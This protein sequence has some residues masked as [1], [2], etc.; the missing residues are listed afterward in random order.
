MDWRR[1]PCRLGELSAAHEVAIYFASTATAFV[2]SP[3]DEG[4]TTTAVTAG[5]YALNAAVELAVVGF[6]VGAGILLDF[7][8]VKNGGFRAEEAHC[9]EDELGGEDALCA[10]DGLG[11]HAALWIF[12]PLDIDDFDACEVTSLIADKAL[13]RNKILAGIGAVESCGFFLTVVHLVNAG[14]F[15]PRIISSTGFRR[16]AHDFE[17]GDRLAS[18]ADRSA[19]AVGTGI[20]ATD[21]DDVLTLSRNVLRLAVEVVVEERLGVV[22]EELHREVNT[23]E[24]TTFDWE[25]AGVCS[26]HGKDN[27][28][29]V[30]TE[31]LCGNIHTDVD[32][33]LK[34]YAFSGEQVYT[35]LYDVLIE[36]HVWNTIHEQPANAIGTL[37]NG[38]QVASL[39]QLVS[40][41]ETGRAGTDDGNLLARALGWGLWSNPAFCPRLVHNGTFDGL[42]SDWGL[43]NAKN[44]GAFARSGAHAT[45]ELRE[46]VGLVEALNSFL[47]EAAIN[48]VVPLRDEIVYGTAGSSAFDDGTG[49]AEGNTALHATCALFAKFTLFHV[50]M[51][52][53]PVLDALLWR[54][55]SWK[56]ASK[57]EESC[58]LAHK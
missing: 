37:E 54:D 38:N 25:V 18:M 6:G 56:F 12:N 5:V 45:S 58:W 11:H 33:C 23:F 10:F 50:L 4:L 52:F 17:L 19:Y 13:C 27:R 44:A 34:G 32:A 43:D 3:D 55:I 9:Q 49:M 35:T 51:E 22:R 42:N 57:F 24:A 41:G 14:P 20:T 15:G 28:I 1:A 53:V 40:R 21:D 29:E 31:L 30:L 8:L 16:T 26:T 2:D 7:E 48:K 39:V 47:P 36:L 46:V